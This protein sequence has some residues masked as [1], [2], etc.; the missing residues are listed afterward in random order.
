MF[1]T[2]RG[3]LQNIV[4]LMQESGPDIHKSDISKWFVSEVFQRCR[5]NCD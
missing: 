5:S 4:A 1:S 2:C 3:V